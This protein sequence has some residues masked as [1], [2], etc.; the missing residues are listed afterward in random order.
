[1]L[2]PRTVLV[3]TSHLPVRRELFWE[4]VHTQGLA[5]GSLMFGELNRVP[6]RPES[7]GQHLRQGFGSAV[8]YL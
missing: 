2:A 6:Y 4:E 7:T 8:T 1:M 5:W 3:S